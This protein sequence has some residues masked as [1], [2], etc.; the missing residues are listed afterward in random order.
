MT[1]MSALETASAI[2]T[3]QTSVI[4]VVE[5]ALDRAAAFLTGLPGR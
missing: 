3:G 5:D 2:R 4:E 1:Q